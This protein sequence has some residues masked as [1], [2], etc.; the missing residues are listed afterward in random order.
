M[1]PTVS[2]PKTRPCTSLSSQ[3]HYLDF[4]PKALIRPREILWAHTS[5]G[6]EVPIHILN[7][8]LSIHESIS[9]PILSFSKHGRRPWIH[10]SSFWWKSL[11]SVTGHTLQIS[12]MTGRSVTLVLTWSAS[13]PEIGFWAD[14]S[15]IIRP[16]LILAW[17]S[18]MPAG[19]LMLVQRMFLFFFFVC[20]VLCLLT[21]SRLKNKDWPGGIRFHLQ[22]WRTA[23]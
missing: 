3:D 18:P 21:T 13:T 5:P 10:P 14:D 23:S 9:M 2:W 15:L 8:C 16:L 17:S 22:G 7:T 19:T 4:L 20:C 11:P 6:E 1:I 12:K